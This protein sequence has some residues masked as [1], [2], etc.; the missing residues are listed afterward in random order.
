MTPIAA[1]KLSYRN[2][3]SL[4]ITLISFFFLVPGITLSMLSVS[5][6]GSINADIPH[7]ESGFL[8]SKSQKGT[9]QKHIN[10]K[11]FDTTRSI[12]NT[13]HDLWTRDYYFVSTMILIFSIIVPFVKGA[14]LFYN[15]FSGKARQ[16]KKIYAFIKAIGKWSM[17]DV[18][19]VAVFLSYL[20]TGATQTTS[21]K[22]VSMMGYNV[23]VHV[24]AGMQAQLHVG[25]WCF[26]TYC[27][28]SLIAL[29]IY[30][31]F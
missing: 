11:I 28:L 20:S 13:V 19:I 12:I 4:L 21:E 7:M 25:F 10:L 30:E 1:H 5:T 16:R 23:D 15:F 8:G 2:K 24:L 3:L 18:F 26:L 6:K 22:S 9:D 14:L 29:Q 17:C 31:D 27:L